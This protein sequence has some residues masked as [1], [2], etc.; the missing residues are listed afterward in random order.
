MAVEALPTGIA[1]RRLRPVE[2]ALLLAFILFSFY[3]IGYGVLAPDSFGA[4]FGW[5]IGADAATL[6]Y[7]TPG[8]PA[9]KAGIRAGDRI[10]WSSL[11]L[12]GRLNLLVP[13]ATYVNETL[14]VT[15]I[16]SGRAATYTL[17]S[18]PFDERTQM[19]GKL[20]VI[21]LVVVQYIAAALVWLRPSKVT[22][23]FLLFQAAPLFNQLA[24]SSIPQFAFNYVGAALSAGAAIAGALVFVTHFP[25]NTPR[26]QLR[27]VAALAVP[28]GIVV[29]TLTLAL[30]AFMFFSSVPPPRW[31][32][33]SI[34][35]LT[36]PV[37]SVLILIAIAV[38]A[39][40]ARGS[41]R[42]RILPVLIAI[43]FQVI[44]TQI[45][46]IYNVEFTG[47]TWFFV[48]LTLADLSGIMVAIAVVN[49]V[50]RDRVIDISFTVSRTVV[51]TI[52]TSL[53]V[54]LFALIDFVS[55][56]FLERLEI[57]LYL[58]A[59]AALAFGVALNSLHSRIDHVVDRVIFRRRHLAEQR[60]HRT[61][62]T[63]MHSESERFIDEALV[64]EAMDAMELASA[65]LFRRLG[66]A[67]SRVVSEG[68]ADDD[69]STLAQDDHLVVHVTAELEP[70]D[71]TTLRWPD[72]IVPKGVGHPLLAV[73]I[74]VRHQLLGFVLYG[75]HRGGE[76]I[77]PDERR[78]LAQLAE[79]A[80]PAYEHIRMSH[81]T[82]AS[83]QW[84]LEKTLLEH[85][86]TLLREMVDALRTVAKQA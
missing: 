13:Q 71:L 8:G 26:N 3:E 67:Y 65:A 54:G 21:V 41:E 36:G 22:C 48:L 80:G 61:A 44:I 40:T 52:L 1:K 85:E 84:M 5:N 75:G 42:Q 62:R 63:M 16:R 50:V 74:V 31:L 49:G 81:L 76:A 77:D 38:S 46:A 27:W 82:Q 7:I 57:T 14:T 25:N 79:A 47:G 53:L 51:Y 24:T 39:Y 11:P 32:L 55:S 4:Y 18:V 30:D 58:E 29:A 19:A 37:T 83:E 68:W 9:E 86:R 2:F 64:V 66:D 10:E 72:A 15:T 6:T 17:R 35:Y 45:N 33:G 78:A 43:A 69:T 28:A 23:A 59:G 20:Q 12:L 70:V 60:L 73:P 34:E 56:K